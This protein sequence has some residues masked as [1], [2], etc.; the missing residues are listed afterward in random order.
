MIVMVLMPGMALGVRTVLVGS[1]GGGVLMIVSVLMQQQVFVTIMRHHL[2]FMP[3]VQQVD[4]HHGRD[5]WQ[6][7]QVAQPANEGQNATGWTDEG[8]HGAEI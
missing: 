6:C 2:H 8:G 7:R 1:A 4:Q 5:L 3:A